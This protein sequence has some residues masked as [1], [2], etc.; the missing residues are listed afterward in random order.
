MTDAAIHDLGYQ[1]YAG[2]RGGAVEARRAL[3]VQGLRAMFGLGRSAKAK[4]V[5]P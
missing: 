3:F 5:P 1:R 2:R 4:I